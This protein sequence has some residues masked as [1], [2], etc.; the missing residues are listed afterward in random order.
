M[1][2]IAPGTEARR[3]QLESYAQEGEDL[4]L[5][6]FFEGRK[7]GSYVDVGAHHPLRFSNTHFFYLRGWRGI[8]I[9]AMPGSM[10]AFR[11]HRPDDINLEL[12]I[13]TEPR[14]V[15]HVFNETAL[16]GLCAEVAERRDGKHGNKITSRMP[17]QTRTLASVL[18]EHVPAGRLIDFLSVDVEG[19]DLEVL[20]S[21]DWKRHRPTIVLAEDLGLRWLDELDR[22]PL[23]AFMR[24]HDYRPVAKT[25]NTLFFQD[26]R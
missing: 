21:G 12:A 18:D 24:S 2:S 8:N 7:S 10:E 16:N 6:R 19:H 25:F 20:R 14:L 26:A 4:V 15:Y 17:M 23:A 9:D 13:S 11:A 22:S 3:C 1:V 5:R